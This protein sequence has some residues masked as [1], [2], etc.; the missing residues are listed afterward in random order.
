MAPRAAEVVEHQSLMQ[1]ICP[2]KSP[3]DNG[4]GIFGKVVFIGPAFLFC[5]THPKE[6]R[7]EI[8]TCNNPEYSPRKSR[9]LRVDIQVC[10][11]YPALF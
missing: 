4:R 6:S 3:S 11:C 8:L 5:T 7:V 2:Q 10:E 9:A 1:L